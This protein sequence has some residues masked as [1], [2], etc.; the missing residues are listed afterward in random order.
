[1]RKIYKYKLPVDGGVVAIDDYIVKILDLQAQDGVPTM[2]A[3]VDS[4]IEAAGP[5]EII[6]IGTGWEL[7]AGIDEYLG[8]V[9][10][11]Y[12]SVWHYFLI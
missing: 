3:I 5:I 8:T 11:E 4:E 9:Q 7:P 6:A 10:D 1:M 2:W 12:G